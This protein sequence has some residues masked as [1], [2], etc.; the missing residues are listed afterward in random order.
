MMVSTP[1]N[2]PEIVVEKS[3]GLTLSEKKWPRLDIRRF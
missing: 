1:V 3:T 2:Y